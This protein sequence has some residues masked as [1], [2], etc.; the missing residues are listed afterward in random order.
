MNMSEIENK[1]T[2]LKRE[3]ADLGLSERESA[4]YL[5]LLERGV[6]M[7]GTKIAI[8]T[9]MHRQHVYTALHVLIEKGL[10]EKMT[11]GKQFRYRAA[12]P[13]ELEKIERR[14]YLRAGIL[15]DELSKMSPLGHDQD[16]EVLVGERAIQQHQMDFVRD[17]IEGETQY[18]IGGSAEEFIELMGE[19][20]EEMLAIQEKKKFITHYIGHQNEDAPLMPYKK[21]SIT[22][23]AKLLKEMPK[24]FLQ[25]TVRRNT[26]EFYSLSGK[27]PILYVIKSARVAD[28]Y[29]AFF[30]MFW[31]LVEKSEQSKT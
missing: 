28:N 5:C 24:G 2:Y 18:I 22:F 8:G 30:H 9:K 10:V 23:K 31:G 11:H 12:P 17:A 29:R 21:S 6:D 13:Q 14:R 3:L 15:A 26:L 20:Y 7:G 16:F 1:K 27:P 19:R 4:I 25:F